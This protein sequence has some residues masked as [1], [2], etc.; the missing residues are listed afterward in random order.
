MG[1][2]NFHVKRSALLAAFCL[3]NLKFLHVIFADQVLTFPT[4]F[5]VFVGGPLQSSLVDVCI[6]NSPV[7]EFVVA[8]E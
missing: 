2:V 1:K 7:F 6:S 4:F 3:Q 5:G 8:A